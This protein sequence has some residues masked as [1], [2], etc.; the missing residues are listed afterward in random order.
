MDYDAYLG[1]LDTHGRALAI[2]V[3]R[4]GLDAPVPTCPEW[5]ARALVDHVGMVHRWA[6]AHVRDAAQGARPELEHAPAD[7]VLDWFRDGHAALV[8][9]LR[10]SGPD[11]PCWAF[12]AGAPKTATFWARRQAHETA[13]HRAD[14]ESATGSMPAFD[15]AFALDGI[16]EL[17]EG[18]Y[19]R[20]GGTLRCDP[21]F[22]L[23]VAPT[24]ADLSWHVTVGPDGREI[25]RDGAGEVDCTLSGPAPDLY[26]QLW[27][28]APA[29]PVT[30]TGDRS[31]V[32]RWRE[33]A[34]VSWS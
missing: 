20:P 22:T 30:V 5:D 23:R 1:E 19:G 25:V 15:P 10:A 26:L 4:A 3:Q 16:G 6:A 2:A 34:R 33:L 13:I 9:T 11:Q 18:F 24:D 27:N 28:R 32:G 7:G 29:N 21:P 31:V 14:A 8:R 17:L 12:L